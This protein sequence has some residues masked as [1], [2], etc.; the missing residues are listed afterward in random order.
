MKKLL[1]VLTICGGFLFSSATAFAAESDSAPW[2]IT[3]QSFVGAENTNPA[4]FDN[5]TFG[6]EYEH[7]NNALSGMGSASEINHLNTIKWLSLL[8]NPFTFVFA[9]MLLVAC[10]GIK[11]TRNERKAEMA[12]LALEERRIALE[13]K[14]FEAGNT[15]SATQPVEGTKPVAKRYPKPAVADAGLSA[16]IVANNPVAGDIN[17][18]GIIDSRDY[19]AAGIDIPFFND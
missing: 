12:R 7:I 11:K 9:G 6:T 3:D 13:E 4:N 15:S 14:R 18:D 2:F 17:G 1:V 8:F 19:G 5:S 16:G 10:L